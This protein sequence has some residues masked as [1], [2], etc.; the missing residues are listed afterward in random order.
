MAPWSLGLLLSFPSD[1]GISHPRFSTPLMGTRREGV[2]MGRFSGTYTIHTHIA[3]TC[4]RY[5]RLLQRSTSEIQPSRYWD[6][7][8]RHL[9][10]YP[11]FR[12]PRE[13]PLRPKGSFCVSRI[14]TLHDSLA[15]L[16]PPTPPPPPF[17]SLL[18]AL[19]T[20]TFPFILYRDAIV[21][22]LAPR[23]SGRMRASRLRASQAAPPPAL[24]NYEPAAVASGLKEVGL[25]LGSG[26]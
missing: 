15:M 5:A 24:C 23:P 19:V 11:L 1:L 17:A 14:P 6:G 7:N 3:I 26:V 8:F 13:T 25:A 12:D 16:H 18:A 10:K 2:R 22:E 20:G 9:V 21:Y 4:Q